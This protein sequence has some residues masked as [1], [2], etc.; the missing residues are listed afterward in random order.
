[1]KRFIA[2][3]LMATVATAS[4]SGCYGRM[5]LTRKVYQLNG[6]VPNK[7][8][9]SLVTWVFIFVPVYGISA[10]ADFVLFNTIE[11]WSGRN[12]VAAG[13]KDFRF[14]KNGETFRVH[15]EKSG[16]NVRYVI[17][18]S[19]KSRHLDTLTIDWN[20]KDGSSRGILL[21]PDRAAEEYR[22]TLQGGK[23][24]VKSSDSGSKG[25]QQVALYAN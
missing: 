1:M 24:L 15:A 14:A 4:I 9:R 6:S 18:R 25:P 5:A 2:S 12:P 20:L 16:D 8:A 11:F 13:K 19:S 23:V 7:F 17:D 10:L 22:A 21:A 3:C